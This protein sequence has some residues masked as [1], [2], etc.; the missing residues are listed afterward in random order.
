MTPIRAG[1]V[2]MITCAVCLAVVIL[3][4]ERVRLEAQAEVELSRLVATRRHIW[5]LQAELARLRAPE[6]I[7]RRAQRAEPRLCSVYDEIFEPVTD[8]LAVADGRP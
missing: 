5:N 1:V 6:E 2:L 8:R 4:G 7:R 3:R